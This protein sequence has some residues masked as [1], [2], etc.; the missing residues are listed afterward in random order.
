D[1]NLPDPGSL[2][3]RAQFR[4]YEWLLWSCGRNPTFWEDWEGVKE[5]AQRTLSFE[6][7]HLPDSLEALWVSDAELSLETTNRTEGTASL[8]VNASGYARLDSARIA[9]PTLS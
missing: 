1:P 2:A 9:T 7:T 8:R 4:L 3:Y 5:G 6:D